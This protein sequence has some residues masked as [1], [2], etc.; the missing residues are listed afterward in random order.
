MWTRVSGKS[1]RR[2]ASQTAAHGL[3]EGDTE[4]F[5]RRFEELGLQDV[6]LVGGKNASLGELY[7]ELAPKGVR[8]PDGFAVTASAY[9]FFLRSAGLAP[10][11]ERTLAGLD[12]RDVDELRRR[13]REVRHAILAASLPAEFERA[14]TDAYDRL[15]RGIPE[16]LDVAVRSSATAEDL[17]EASFAAQ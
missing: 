10:V 2:S 6:P 17:P 16:P 12:T 11:I 4:E 3:P 13:G 9:R 14:V 8:V 7:R 1:R 15:G 5:I